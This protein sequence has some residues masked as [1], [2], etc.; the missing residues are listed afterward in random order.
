MNKEE[1]KFSNVNTP[2]ILNPGEVVVPGK[3]YLSSSS[4]PQ[5]AKKPYSY[6]KSFLIYSLM[7]LPGLSAYSFFSILS[8]TT[9]ASGLELM[10]LVFLPLMF[11]VVAAPFAVLLGILRIRKVTDRRDQLNTFFLISLIVL[12]SLLLAYDIF[13]H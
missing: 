8:K 9:Q 5:P 7:C 3:Q 11:G 12:M 2:G 4:L 10:F 1:N 6:E 13:L